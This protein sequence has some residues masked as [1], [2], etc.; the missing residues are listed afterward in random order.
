MG[1]PSGPG[2]KNLLQRRSRRRCTIDPWVGKI[3]WKRA[4]QCFCLENPM[5]RGTWQ[6]IVQRVTKS[7]TWRNRLSM[8]AGMIRDRDEEIHKVRAGRVVSARTSVLV[9]WVCWMCFSAWKF[10]KPHTVGIFMEASLHK[11]EWQMSE[12][13]RSVVS[14]S[15]RPHGL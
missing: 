5:D 1:S 15:L 4:R 6:A 14:D 2:I 3:P 7:W 10:S 9:E 8:H 13:H 11:H 12:W